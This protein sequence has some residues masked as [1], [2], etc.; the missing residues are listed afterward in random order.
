[1]A[2]SS[3]NT[4]IATSQTTLLAMTDTRLT[5]FLGRFVKFASDFQGTIISNPL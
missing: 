3:F 5:E 1:V 2:I 4:G